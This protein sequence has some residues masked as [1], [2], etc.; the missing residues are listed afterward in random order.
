MLYDDL[1]VDID[2]LKS[3]LFPMIKDKMPVK[4]KEL[5]K[6]VD[7]F[8]TTEN[9]FSRD[10][11]VDL[12]ISQKVKVDKD[13]VAFALQL[14]VQFG[15]AIERKFE[16]DAVKRYEHLHPHS[17]HD[18]FI[19]VKCKKIIE[20]TNDELEKIQD[21]LIFRKG[22]KPL[23]HKLE[24]YG[25][26]DACSYVK[27]STSFPITFAKEDDIVTFDRFDSQ[28]A[29]KK[30]LAELGFILGEKITVIKNSGFGPVVL[31]VKGTRVALGR[32][33]AQKIYIKS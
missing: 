25:V 31:E 17:H 15:F 10:D 33:Q 8:I 30:R 28:A 24:V 32:G 16:G 21:S 18:H 2:E 7:I 11:F 13:A 12:L 27:S 26:C 5:D 4:Q 23:Y 14:L 9:H 20:F 3:R 29:Q 22:C 6:L 19:C 1:P